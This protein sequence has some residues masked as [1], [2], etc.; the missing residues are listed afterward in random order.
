M[1]SRKIN[2]R[3]WPAMIGIPV[4]IGFALAGDRNSV[5][6]GL[7]ALLICDGLTRLYSLA[8]EDRDGFPSTTHL[9]SAALGHASTVLLGA[10]L[11]LHHAVGVGLLV[12]AG[13]T[14]VAGWLLQRAVAPG[15][16]S[17]SSALR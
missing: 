14:A 9:R 5:E 17:T 16:G 8:T 13:G 6:N 4:L 10:G 15:R 2:V 12:L 1:A 3:A 7:S 11:C